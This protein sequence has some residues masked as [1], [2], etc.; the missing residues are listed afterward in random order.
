MPTPYVSGDTSIPNR[1]LNGSATV[2]WI[3]DSISQ[4]FENRLLQV[5]RVTPAGIGFRGTVF[6]S[7]GAPT[8]A[9]VGA[10]GF[11]ATGLL[12]E[13]NY[14]PLQTKEAVFNGNAIATSG[15]PAAIDMRLMSAAPDLLA[16]GRNTVLFGGIDWLTGSSLNLRCVM[17]RNAN[18]SNG[19]IRNY[20]RGGSSASVPRGTGSFLALQASPARY[21]AD[22]IPFTAPN[23]GED[24]ILEAQ[25]H[26]GASPING[27]NFVLCAALVT[28]G[29]S[30][31]TYIPAS[32]G[33]WDILKWTDTTVISDAAL[34]GV[35]PLLNVTDVVVSLGQNNGTGQTSAQFLASLL[36]VVTRIR[37]ALPG[38][39]IIFMPTYDTNNAGSGP[40]LAGFADAHYAAQQQTPNSCFLNLFKAAGVW[41]QL[42]ALGMFTDGVH[43]SEAGK[44]YFIQ[45]IQS[46]LDTLISGIRATAAGRYADQEDIEDIFGRANV[47][48]WAQFDSSGVQDLARVQRAL[49]EA[50]ATIDD[51]FR[52]GSIGVPLTISASVSTVATWAATLAGARLYR[53]RTANAANSAA[54]PM[55]ASVSISAGADVSASVTQPV[56]PYS[57]L[58]AGVRAQ[59][60]RCKAGATRIDAVV[61][62][63]T[64][65]PSVSN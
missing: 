42:N 52:G 58:V 25:S 7:L 59:M 12:T 11:G 62:C 10:G 9:A 22:D 29:G 45:T 43:P 48:A 3:G 40:H 60:A 46:L 47:A 20:V 63:G 55:T 49:E 15:A 44:V 16:G 18:S 4:A 38:S 21:L 39:S 32:N 53:S 24:I 54:S 27:S 13:T 1:W 61:L 33:G 26:N 14:S 56:D 2:L 50:D 64:N 51:F 37:V 28:T 35:L 6:S 30:G 5:L 65:A 8:W 36:L 19:I 23:A 41:S 57:A 34:S 17:Y 31:F